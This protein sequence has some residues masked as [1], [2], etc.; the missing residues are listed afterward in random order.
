M[1][2]H[3]LTNTHTP[4]HLHKLLPTVYYSC[5]LVVSSYH[6]SYKQYFD[7]LLDYKKVETYCY[8]KKKISK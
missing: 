2:I 4:T 1:H 7:I 6:K 8:K 3:I 5:H